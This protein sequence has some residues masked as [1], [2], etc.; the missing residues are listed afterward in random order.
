MH[1]VY[2]NFFQITRK[3]KNSKFRFIKPILYT[4]TDEERESQ[5]TTK[6]SIILSQQNTCNIENIIQ[7]K[8]DIYSDTLR[9]FLPTD[10]RILKSNWFSHSDLKAYEFYVNNLC[11]SP[12]KK[13]S[14]GCLLRKWED[15]PGRN[16]SPL[17]SCTLNKMVNSKKN[18]SDNKKSVIAS[19][20]AIET[21]TEEI[22]RQQSCSS[23]DLFDS[24]DESCSPKNTPQKL[25]LTK[26]Y[27]SDSGIEHFETF[28]N[29]SSEIVEDICNTS[30]SENE[31]SKNTSNM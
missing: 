12:N 7:E 17:R 30:S 6:V 8:T 4:R 9:S 20:S 24:A 25:E 5:I 14:Y 1:L 11:L 22:S 21:A 23:P 31:R 10:R 29:N 16:K 28:L 3:R 13:S 15:I 27:K 19:E 18:L 2:G 26:I